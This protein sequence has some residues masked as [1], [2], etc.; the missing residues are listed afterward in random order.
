MKGAVKFLHHNE[1]EILNSA[2][3]LQLVHLLSRLELATY[4]WFGP[5]GLVSLDD[6]W[7]WKSLVFYPRN[8]NAEDVHNGAVDFE[9][10]WAELMKILARIIELRLAYTTD[11]T[12][13]GQLD[14]DDRTSSAAEIQCLL[15]VWER[16]L[17][18]SF[19]PTSA[20]SGTKRFVKSLNLKELSPPIYYRSLNIAVAMGTHLIERSFDVSPPFHPGIC[21]VFTYSRCWI[22]AGTIHQASFHCKSIK[23]LHWRVRHVAMWSL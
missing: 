18:P 4:R 9:V 22:Y 12:I 3:G 11:G 15:R 13:K 20:P 14:T 7:R 17:P 23:N 21:H 1:Q 5:R 10:A 8:S 19:Q 6:I 16:T 2:T